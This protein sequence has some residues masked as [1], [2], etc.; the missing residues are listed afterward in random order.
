MTK[1]KKKPLAKN[2]AID[3]VKNVLSK[4][5]G[6]IQLTLEETKS[7]VEYTNN[8]SDKCMLNILAIEFGQGFRHFEGCGSIKEFVTKHMK[9]KYNTFH[10]RLTAARVA[11]SIGG[12]D[13]L[14]KH[15]DDA[16]RAM[17]NLHVEQ[18][19]EVY[20]RIK[21]E[22]EAKE[23]KDVKLNIELVEKT[24]KELYPNKAKVSNKPKLKQV[25][26]KQISKFFGALLADAENAVPNFAKAV[27]DNF[28][29][30]Q[31]KALIKLLKDLDEPELDLEGA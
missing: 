12:Y 7:I 16:M 25:T 4:P 14:G 27:K 10:H 11:F 23:D 20:N 30:T 9:L 18:R 8:L 21:A 17:K 3:L 2:N 29:S 26:D 28:S 22:K 1:P 19:R 15:P 5:E 6:E 31:R 13:M 24:I